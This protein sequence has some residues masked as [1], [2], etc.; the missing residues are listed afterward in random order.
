MWNRLVR[1][2]AVSYCTLRFSTENKRFLQ[3]AF[4]LLSVGF[5]VERCLI[6]ALQNPRHGCL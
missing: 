1:L 4:Q 6:L 3:I 5:K 2:L